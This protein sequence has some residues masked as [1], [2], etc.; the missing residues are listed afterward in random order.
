MSQTEGCKWWKRPSSWIPLWRWR[1]WHHIWRDLWRCSETKG[2]WRKKTPEEDDSFRLTQTG[3]L[4]F[5]S[6][7]PA[8]PIKQIQPIVSFWVSPEVGTIE[9]AVKAFQTKNLCIWTN[10]TMFGSTQRLKNGKQSRQ[11]YHGLN[12]NL[13]TNWVAEFFCI[14]LVAYLKQLGQH[15]SS[16]TGTKM[17]MRRYFKLTSNLERTLSPDLVRN[18]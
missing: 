10:A 15:C 7:C 3:S 18:L 16:Q 12:W 4:L 13:S 5:C 8:M 9:E 17:E 14:S 2:R 6:L 1:S 11:S